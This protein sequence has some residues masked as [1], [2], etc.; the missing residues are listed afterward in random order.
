MRNEN[1]RLIPFYQGQGSQRRSLDV[2][3]EF[4]GLTRGEDNAITQPTLATA[5]Q[6]AVIRL[7]TRYGCVSAESVAYWH[8]LMQIS[9]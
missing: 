2:M 9:F 5:L 6:Q 4:L 7:G 3:L 8:G 1:A